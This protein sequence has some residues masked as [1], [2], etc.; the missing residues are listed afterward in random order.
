MVMSI[1][2]PTAS[3]AATAVP[4]VLSPADRA[5]LSSRIRA[6]RTE[7]RDLLRAKIVWAAG[8]GDPNVA[9]SATLEIH[10][11]TVRKWRGRFAEDGLEGLR[12]LPRSGRP[13]V[14]SAVQAAEVKAMACELPAESDLPL[15]RWSSTDLATEAIKRGIVDSISASTVRRWLH[16]DAIKPWQHRSWIFP[17]DPDFATKAGRVLDLYARTWQGHEL[18]EDEYVISADERSQLQALRRRHP[19]RPP[20]PGQT[21]RVEFEY[22]RGG[23]L[24]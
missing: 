20:G 19:D 18:G 12:D 9:I 11:D 14:F 15:S 13:K 24:A 2:A 10:V 6:A 22:I 3:L 8:H 5:V 1:T 16:A 4:I 7:Q 23:T 21:R 17:R